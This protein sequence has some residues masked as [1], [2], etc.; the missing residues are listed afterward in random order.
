[1]HVEFLVEELS[2]ETALKELLPK[3][4]G[5]AITFGIR[6]HEG[7]LDLLR[8]LP[9]RLRGYKAMLNGNYDLRI[10]VLVDRDSEDCRSRK[11]HLEDVATDAGLV[12]KSRANGGNFQVLNRLAIQELEAWFF[13][14]CEAVAQAYPGFDP[15]LWRKSRYRDSDAIDHTWETLGLELQ[16]VGHH[17][18]RY[19]KV[20]GAREIASHM[21]P[22]RNRSPS[23]QAFCSGLLDLVR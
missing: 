20:R 1:M 11:A 7:K 21:A 22:S 3:I 4:L 5:E 6:T 12:T 10:V 17:Q 18:G 9:N 2:A 19:E 8:S 16:K 14:D 15:Q 13:G 23:F